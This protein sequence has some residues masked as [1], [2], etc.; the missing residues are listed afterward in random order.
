VIVGAKKVEQLDDNIAAT[1]VELNADELAK[2]DA[3][4]ELP[5]EYPGWMLERQGEPRRAQVKESSRRSPK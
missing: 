2:L 3:V 4:S 1:K 5:A